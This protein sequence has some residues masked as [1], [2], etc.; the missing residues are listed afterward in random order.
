MTLTLKAARV[1]ANLTQN[2]ASKAIGVSTSTLFL[3]EQGKRY[4]DAIQIKKIEDVYNIAFADLIFLHDG[5]I[6][7]C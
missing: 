4:P 3:W 5:T 1:N 2:E 6:K 7:S